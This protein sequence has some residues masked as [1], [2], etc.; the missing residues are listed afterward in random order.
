V[1]HRSYKKRKEEKQEDAS[2]TRQERRHLGNRENDHKFEG[3]NRRKI[4]EL[5]KHSKNN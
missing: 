4:K 2:E 3:S 5:K 1:F